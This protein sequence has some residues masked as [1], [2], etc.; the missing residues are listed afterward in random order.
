MLLPLSPRAVP[1]MQRQLPQ[2][3][4]V[5]SFNVAG[6]PVVVAV[7]SARGH[8]VLCV[9]DLGLS[10]MHACECYGVFYMQ[11]FLHSVLIRRHLL[12]HGGVGHLRP[13]G[14]HVW[15]LLLQLLETL[16]LLRR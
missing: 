6:R 7:H 15:E 13:P 4:C 11:R 9:R 1:E 5:L 12:G 2:R 16:P 8:L 10:G 14:S 3:Q